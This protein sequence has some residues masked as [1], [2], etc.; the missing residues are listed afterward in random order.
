MMQQKKVFVKYILK[1]QDI[2]SFIHKLTRW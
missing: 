2:N 1:R